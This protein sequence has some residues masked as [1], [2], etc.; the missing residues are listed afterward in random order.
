MKLKLCRDCKWSVLPSTERRSFSESRLRCSNDYVN[1]DDNWSLASTE[2]HPAKDCNY[3][4]D[5]R[6]P[7]PCGKRGAR[8][9]PKP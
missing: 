5:R 4:R 8:W 2:P 1:A 7:A 3:E 9:E 6:W